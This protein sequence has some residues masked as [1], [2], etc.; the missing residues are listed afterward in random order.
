LRL[1]SGN[2]S[3]ISEINSTSTES[4]TI[5]DTPVQTAVSE[6]SYDQSDMR[7]DKTLAQQ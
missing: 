3:T 4:I 6:K 7:Y 2:N 5:S 1:T